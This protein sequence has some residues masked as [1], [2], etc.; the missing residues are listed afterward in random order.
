[1][2]TGNEQN[3]E[4]VSA[5]PNRRTFIVTGLGVAAAPLLSR[6]ASVRLPRRRMMLSVKLPSRFALGGNR[7]TAQ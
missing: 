4:N 2:T 7:L 6:V 3:E 5:M 1:M